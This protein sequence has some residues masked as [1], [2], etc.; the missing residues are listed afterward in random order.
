MVLILNGGTTSF[1]TCANKE[2]ETIERTSNSVLGRDIFIFIKKI[3]FNNEVNIVIN[4]DLKK[5]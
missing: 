3:H 5:H 4:N 2:M 1:S